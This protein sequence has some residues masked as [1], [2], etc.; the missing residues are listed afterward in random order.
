MFVAFNPAVNSARSAA[1]LASPTLKSAFAHAHSPS[2]PSSSRASSNSTAVF[3]TGVAMPANT[4]NVKSRRAPLVPPSLPPPSQSYTM[5]SGSSQPGTP[6]FLSVPTLPPVF[7]PPHAPTLMPTPVTP[8][9]GLG[10]SY[11]LHADLVPS[12]AF[13]AAVHMRMTLIQG[14]S[15]FKDRRA[16]ARA[17]RIPSLR[18]PPTAAPFPTPAEERSINMPI[19]LAHTLPHPPDAGSGAIERLGLGLSGLRLGGNA[20]TPALETIQQIH[21]DD[22]MMAEMEEGRF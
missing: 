22:E 21:L 17:L 3:A 14:P 18:A 6:R 19:R 10:D 15:S 13:V 2:C 7:A 9:T 12:Q 8:E 4:T 11:F 20:M 1:S 5:I 16:N